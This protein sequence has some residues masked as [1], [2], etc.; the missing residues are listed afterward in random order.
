MNNKAAKLVWWDE[1]Y[2]A[3]MALQRVIEAKLRD[4]S[5]AAISSSE[6]SSNFSYLLPQAWES[7]K[8]KQE[9][10]KAWDRIISTKF[11]TAWWKMSEYIPIFGSSTVRWI[12][13][14]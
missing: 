8:V 10:L 6:W 9:K 1:S 11:I 7:Q 14:S 12:W 5:G 4:E 2:S 13:W 3:L